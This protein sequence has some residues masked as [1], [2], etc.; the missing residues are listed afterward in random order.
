[1]GGHGTSPYE[2]NTQQSPVL[3][4]SITPQPA[5]SW[6]NTQAFSGMDST[7]RCPQS[8]HV[9]VHRRTAVSAGVGSGVVMA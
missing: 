5:H 9:S 3:G 4:R 2:Q 1:M 8:G 7:L 6:K